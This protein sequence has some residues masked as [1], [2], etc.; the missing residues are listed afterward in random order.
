VLEKDG[1][2]LYRS[3]EKL[4][5]ITKSKKGQIY[6]TCDN[7]SRKANI[8]CKNCLLKHIIEGKRE[9]RIEVMGRGAR[10]REQLLNDLE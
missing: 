9:G 1:D 5:C 7:K 2:Q 10:R 4:R 8:L 3:F 6:P